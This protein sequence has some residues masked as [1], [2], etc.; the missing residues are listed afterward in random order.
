MPSIGIRVEQLIAQVAVDH[1]GTLGE[2]HD[3]AQRRPFERTGA[4]GPQPGDGAQNGT[5]SGAACAHDE[6]ALIAAQFKGQIIHQ[7]FRSVRRAHGQLV[8]LHP[9]A[10]VRPLPGS[11]LALRALPPHRIHPDSSHNMPRRCTP[12]R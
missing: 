11:P 10:V 2:E 12:A 8:Q 9:A 4:N 7:C 1:V 3:V 6:E 5:L